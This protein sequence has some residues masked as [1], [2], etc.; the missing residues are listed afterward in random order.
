MVTLLEQA[1]ADKAF[2]GVVWKVYQGD[3]LVRE[4]VAGWLT[5]DSDEPVTFS[6]R[7]DLASVT[8]PF[9]SAAILLLADRR[10]VDLE[11]YA[12]SYLPELDDS[13]KR[14]ITVAQLL[15]HTAGLVSN[16]ELHKA[17]TS[18]NALRGVLFSHPLVSS[19]QQQVL[20]TSIGYQYLG[21]IVERLSGASLQR[22][23]KD[24]VFVPLGFQ[25]MSFMPEDRTNIA[26]TEYSRFRRR[27]LI[28]EVHDDNCYVLGGSGGHA[29]LFSDAED[30]CGFGRTLVGSEG[31]FLS[32]T[33]IEGLFSNLTARLNE[34]RSY[35]FVLNDP[36]FG[37]WN[38]DT[39]S[40][41]GFTGTSLCIVPEAGVVS[42]LLTN[43]VYPTRRN[44]KI[45][46]VRY[47]LH[48]A[49]KDEIEWYSS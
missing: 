46:D 11:N 19:P 6:T 8:K 32:K 7:Y 26:P 40:H 31:T 15:T 2:P 3:D 27:L 28:G 16:P 33:S 36:Q 47:K 9:V 24:N 17:Y 22:F 4:E 13:E 23:L 44:E 43:R 20:Y 34:D 39:F 1:V 38:A 48:T 30:V 25:T 5:Y 42:V 18:E 37:D 14:H 12:S 41:T 35:G 45:R 49:L 10:Q 29:G 21:Y